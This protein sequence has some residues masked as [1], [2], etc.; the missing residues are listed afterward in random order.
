MIFSLKKYANNKN[1]N[2]TII[3]LN[4][5]EAK[6]L[7]DRTII[8]PLTKAELQKKTNKKGKRFNIYSYIA[9]T[10]YLKKY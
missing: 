8:C 3:N 2:A 4:E 7:A 9:I 6:G 5:S 1:P 10:L